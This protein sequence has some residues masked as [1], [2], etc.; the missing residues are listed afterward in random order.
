MKSSGIN[1]QCIYRQI[2]CY[3]PGLL[4]CLND[5][6]PISCN[7]ILIVCWI[8]CTALVLA[9]CGK[10]YC[11]PNVPK[12]YWLYFASQH[13]L[14][15]HCTWINY[16]IWQIQA[17]WITRYLYKWL[18]HYTIQL[19][20][21]WMISIIILYYRV[22]CI[23]HMISSSINQ[24]YWLYIWNIPNI[25]WTNFLKLFSILVF[26]CKSSDTRYRFII[27][28]NKLENIK[29]I[30]NDRKWSYRRLYYIFEN[31]FLG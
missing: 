5:N 7:P 29:N 4:L 6:F 1:L 22:E 17:C 3:T 18:Q 12:K 31:Y 20:S 27:D 21:F 24:Q 25:N 11:N 9:S 10:G 19:W 15:I 13:Q 26:W 8:T 16:L 2:R 28:M 14:R 30:A 23:I